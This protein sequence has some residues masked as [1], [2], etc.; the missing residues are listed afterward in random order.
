MVPAVGPAVSAVPAVPTVPSRSSCASATV[1][2]TLCSAH[3]MRATKT[4]ATMADVALPDPYTFGPRLC[5]DLAEG[6]VR[7]WLVPDGVGGYAMG[8]VSGLRTRRYHALLVAAAAGGST[9]RVG[10]ASLDPVLAL[11]S[12]AEVRLGTHEWASGAISP[13]GN[14]L[15]A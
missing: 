7:E 6:A 15:L 9:R 5:G 2:S 10:L 13:A 3:E 12:G 1:A 14:T 11:P 8:T 4:T